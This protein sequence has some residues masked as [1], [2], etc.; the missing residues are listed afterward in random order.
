MIWGYRAHQ[1][2]E[3]LIYKRPFILYKVR[4]KAKTF[5]QLVRLLRERENYS[6]SFF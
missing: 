4:T 6:Y 2:M 5:P 1:L 3:K